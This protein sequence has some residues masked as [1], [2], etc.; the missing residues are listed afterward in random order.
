[1]PGRE[2]AAVCVVIERIAAGAT[3]SAMAS[4]MG[5]SRGTVAEWW[6]RWCSEGPEG[7]RDRSIR[8]HRSPCRSD[9][10]AEEGICRLRRSSK[11]APAYLAAR[12]RVLQAT[13]SG[14]C[15]VAD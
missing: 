3:Q 13:V 1:M 9:P 14:S 6:H 10:A 7:L 4:Q 11:R 5:L 8:P 12:A 15:G 2:G